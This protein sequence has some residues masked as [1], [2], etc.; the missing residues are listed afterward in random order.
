MGVLRSEL[1]AYFSDILKPELFKDYAPNGLQVEGKNTIKKIISAVTASRYVIEQCIHFNAD[2]LLVHHGLFWPGESAVITGLKKQRIAQLLNHDIN[3]FAYHLPL[4]AHKEFGN[5]IQLAHLFDIDVIGTLDHSANKLGL[6]FY[7]QLSTAIS[8]Q[9]FAAKI[10]SQLNRAPLVINGN[11]KIIEKLAWC[12]GAA[13]DALQYAIDAGLD[14]FITGEVSER[15][16][17]LAQEADI[18]FIA[19]GHH[20]TERYGVQALG[21]HLTQ[22]FDIKHQFIDE[23]NPV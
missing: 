4:D 20:A 12:T 18:C 16:Y 10:Q 19:A 21:K 15:T 13:Q 11:N 3:L 14:A 7:G 17:H 5:N 23:P 1:N 6:V 22:V 8:S 2:A 9:Q